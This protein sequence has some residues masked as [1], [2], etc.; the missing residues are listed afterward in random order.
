MDACDYDI[1]VGSLNLSPNM[2]LKHD[3]SDGPVGQLVVD[4]SIGGSIEASGSWSVE[5]KIWFKTFS[6]AGHV[7]IL[8]TEFSLENRVILGR[9]SNGQIGFSRGLDT[10]KANAG[11]L[12]IKI[13]GSWLSWLFNVLSQVLSG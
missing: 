6:L 4:A 7:D 2:N 5:K 3:G 12:N 13:S 1:N 11:S 10:C 8:A 9:K